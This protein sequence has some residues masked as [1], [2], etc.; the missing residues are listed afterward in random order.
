MLLFCRKSAKLATKCWNMN[1][2]SGWNFKMCDFFPINM[3]LF[4]IFLAKFTINN[5]NMNTFRG[6][7]FLNPRLSNNICYYFAKNL[8]NSRFKKKLS[9]LYIECCEE[10]VFLILNF[11]KSP[12]Y[13]YWILWWVRFTNIEFCEESILS[14]I[15][16]VKSVFFRY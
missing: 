1:F 12:F 15:N 4:H 8:Q 11:V 6:I 9:C 3:L 10:S 13:Q 14:I 2:P 5:Q 7:H 16:F